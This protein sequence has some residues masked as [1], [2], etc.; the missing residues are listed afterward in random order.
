VALPIDLQS[1]ETVTHACAIVP[2][3][4]KELIRLEQMAA[5]VALDVGM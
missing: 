5:N 3:A 4:P 1:N 2:V